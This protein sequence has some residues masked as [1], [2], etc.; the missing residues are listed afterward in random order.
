M[1]LWKGTST[2]LAS[3]LINRLVD[4]IYRAYL[5]RLV[6]AET[7]GLF[8]IALPLY[9]ILLLL[10]GAAVASAV[11]TLVAER[12]AAGDRP[13]VTRVFRLAL[14]I[15][16]IGG[17][18]T[19]TLLLF[20]GGFIT[21]RVLRDPRLHLMLLSIA[22]AILVVSIAGV[23][24]GYFQGHQQMLPV[25]LAQLL[26]QAATLGVTIGLLLSVA[27][28]DPAIRLALMGS[29]LTAGEMVGLATLQV[30]WARL[31][32][33]SQPTSPL[34]APT[35]SRG[36]VIQKIISQAGPVTL[37]RLVASLSMAIGTVLIPGQL[38]ASGYSRS[39]ATSMYGL[40]T[41]LAMP[42]VAFPSLIT[43][44]VSYNLIPA[45]SA[46]RARKDH[47]RVRTLFEKAHQFTL[48]ATLPL[49]VSALIFPGEISHLIY[50]TAAPAAALQTLALFA[51]LLY[52]E[53]IE[54]GVLQGLS[55]PGLNLRNYAISEVVTILLF[56]VL[57]QPW[58][59]VGAALAIALGIMV[60]AIL[61]YLA[62]SSC[63]VDQPSALAVF[64]PP[65]IAGLIMAVVA[66]C[67]ISLSRA[68][69]GPGPASMAGPLAMGLA[70][71]ALTFRLIGRQ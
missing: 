71:Y 5:V 60:E 15:T 70:L 14:I 26:E 58:G 9:F 64:L 40:L 32:R 1:G 39:E 11:G 23:Y 4:F 57:I 18:L 48:W 44:A 34:T 47:T 67:L 25:A 62:A 6:G 36:E 41:G 52:I 54:S 22:P 29:G 49:V 56:F 66:G 19:S 8:Q 30:F 51:P 50:G 33:T 37:T 3:N 68:T 63:L 46:A 53:Q 38:M 20:G 42:I 24:R 21:E 12:L 31:K 16:V 2:L 17:S 65:L 10:S 13:G 35:I 43:F 59:L 27:T 61:D 45:I 7:I 55:R 69:V 28:D